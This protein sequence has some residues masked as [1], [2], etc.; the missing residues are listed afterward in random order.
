MLPYL[1]NLTRRFHA[2]NPKAVTLPH[3]Y[4]HANVKTEEQS[5]WK[6]QPKC[7]NAQV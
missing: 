3:T 7:V 5:P 1:G 4:T 6:L 2:L